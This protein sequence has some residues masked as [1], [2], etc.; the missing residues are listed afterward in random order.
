[1]LTGNT[2]ANNSFSLNVSSGSGLTLPVSTDYASAYADA[3]QA[4]SNA[5][6]KVDGVQYTRSS[7]LV[8]DAMTG[9]TLNLRAVSS[10]T[11]TI[12]LTRD[13]TAVSDKIKALVLSYNDAVSM[14]NVLSDPKSTVETY[15][16]TL[17]GDSII[18]TVKDQ[19][20]NMFLPTVSARQSGVTVNSLRDLGVSV[21]VTGVMTL[22][23][24]KMGSALS[25]H[26]DEVVTAFSK[27]FN[28][29]GEFTPT[30]VDIGIAG[31]ASRALTKL[32][33]TTGQ[34]QTQ[35]NSAVTQNKKY[36]EDLAKLQI[37]MDGLLARYQKQFAAMDSMVGRNNAL[38]T[39][40]KST[41]DGMAKQNN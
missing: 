32:L 38:K 41:F 1:V 40:L 5:V 20:R 39:S 12:D 13:N 19:L 2:G 36:Q 9:V 14:L 15:G 18:R 24:A 3:Y 23:E 31:N 29:L 27:N 33:K 10:S 35:S 17:V 11:S 6:F 8:T 34:I 25:S 28:D 22:D 26:F 21:N 7:N 4:S 30:T 37:R 16:G